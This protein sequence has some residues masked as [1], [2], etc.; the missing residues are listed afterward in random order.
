MKSLLLCCAGA[1]FLLTAHAQT[2]S[3]LF[4]TG[5]NAPGGGAI[6]GGAAI[7][8]ADGQ[9]VRHLW[10]A[11]PKN[12]LCRIDPDVSASGPHTIN[13]STCIQTAAGIRLVPG[14][15]TFDPNTNALYMVD[16]Q[17]K[18]VGVFRF[19]YLPSGDSGQGLMNLTQQEVLGGVS[20]GSGICGIGSNLPTSVTLGPDGNLYLGFQKNGNIMRI[21]APQTEPLPCSNI[22]PNIG[23]TTDN[24]SDFGVAWIG[25]DLFGVDTA[26]PDR[27]AGMDNCFTPANGFVPCPGQRFFNVINPR[28]VVSD[29]PY[30]S[31]NGN[32]LY[33]WD[34]QVVT[35]ISNVNNAV[36]GPIV[37]QN[38]GGV[39]QFIGA[40]AVDATNPANEVLYV[41]DDP[42][43]GAVDGAARW[44]QVTGA[45]PAP[46]APGT[47]AGVI[48]TAGD[49]NATVSWTPAQDGQPVT[50]FT[51]RNSFASNG[52]TAPDVIVSATPGTTIVPS[53]VAVSGLT[54]GISYQFEVLATNAV[55]SSA[56]SAPSNTVTPRA[57]TIPGAPTGAV[58]SA[59]N[60]SAQV[61]WTAGAD[62]GS[63][64]TSNTVTALI[65]GAPSGITVTV[66]GN[67][68]GA[69]VTGLTNGVTY[70][71]TVHATNA[72][73]NGP[74][75]A[76][77]NPVTP[78]GPPPPP[79]SA[80]LSLTMIGPA[81]VSF[82]GSASYQLTVV[83]TGS[84]AA[85]QVIVTDNLPPIGASVQ[86]AIAS[87]GSCQYSG[88]T[89][90]CNLGSIALGSSASITLA[91]TILAQGA[92]QASAQIEDAKG[93]PVADPT[94][95]NNA[96]SVTT[97]ILG[98][99]STTDIQVT[100]S[101]QNGGP[102][103]GAADSFTWQIKNGGNQ[104]ANSVVFAS[105]LPSG[106]PF[107]GASSPQ[108][109]C[110]GP[111]PGSGGTIT[112]SAAS[113]AVGQTM[114]VTVNFTAATAGT[115]SVTGTATFN[116]TDTNT[117]NNLFV[118]GIQV[119]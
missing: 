40:A 41:G 106:L 57:A 25:H 34:H 36:T 64:I 91:E 63:P 49:G 75:S 100:G 116:G 93:A 83:N 24:R 79:P 8:A 23:S 54:D 47:P 3:T 65:G 55:G 6:L 111:T 56:L 52:T 58:A 44:T 19:H 18:S 9:L 102:N 10:S 66:A 89:L 88:T 12:G 7:G 97:T 80:D 118:V 50:S 119:K 69:V 17:A 71:F 13:R 29:Q 110:T 112:C 103:A 32:T 101:A 94:P 113:L 68:T 67:A 2:T 43:N 117:A 11:D 45:T 14:Q 76:P 39:F 82:G 59:L 38:Y 95:A 15:L 72:V 105:T 61:A 90:T 62:G 86:S 5:I 99:T 21:L 109:S 92:N 114:A 4:A 74:E 78:A 22:Q 115:S 87:Q 31:L 1:A 26:A 96:A 20:G 70:A 60:A 85:A 30:P 33:Y 108:G 16:A 48:A 84:A 81:S 27:W 37:T 35:R 53:S 28:S 98:P 46:A 73:G 104:L 77:T 51:V 107:A 42:S